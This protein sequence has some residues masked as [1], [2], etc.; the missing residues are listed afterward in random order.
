MKSELPEAVLDSGA[1]VGFVADVSFLTSG[2]YCN[3]KYGTV[4]YR[5]KVE[6]LSVKF[7]LHVRSKKITKI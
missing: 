4:K 3:I 5:I 6:I 7:W 1:A 2:L